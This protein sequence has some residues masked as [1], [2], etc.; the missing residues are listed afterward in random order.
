[1]SSRLIVAAA[2]LFSAGLT[3][4]AARGGQAVPAAPEAAQHQLFPVEIVFEPALSAPGTLSIR[5][6]SGWTI[7]VAAPASGV[8]LQVPE[9]PASLRLVVGERQFERT[10]KVTPGS[11]GDA[12]SCVWSLPE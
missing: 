6:E 7:E 1:M 4:C 12:S 8:E 9:G 5:H 2:L 11:G 3:S 10:L